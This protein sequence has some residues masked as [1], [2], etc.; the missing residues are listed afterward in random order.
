M[1]AGRMWKDP[2]EMYMD[3]SALV[4]VTSSNEYI[5]IINFDCAL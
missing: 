5:S 4:N 2:S 1:R 3:F